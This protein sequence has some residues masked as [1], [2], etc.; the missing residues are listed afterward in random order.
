MKK[1]QLTKE[2]LEKMKKELDELKSVKRAK[3]LDRLHNAR[4]MGDLSEN[5]EYAAAKD[6]LEIVEERIAELEVLLANTEIVE[7]HG[8]NGEIEI[9]SRVLLESH[10]GKEEFVIVGEFEADPV[11][12]KISHTSPLGQA[13]LRKKVGESIEID[14]PIGKLT[15]KILDIR[16]N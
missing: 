15:Y 2:G 6:D 13:L 10:I 12:K 8:K 9:G 11:T 14:V 1:T 16:R 7:N 3:A 5:S 4:A